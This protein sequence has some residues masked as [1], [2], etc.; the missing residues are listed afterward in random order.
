MKGQ[1]NKFIDFYGT[2]GKIYK[3]PPI[4][5]VVEVPVKKVEPVKKVKEGTQQ[6]GEDEARVDE[7]DS[8][9][10]LIK[11][12][13]VKLE[14]LGESINTIVNNKGYQMNKNQLE[15]LGWGVGYSQES[16]T[17]K[18]WKLQNSKGKTDM[19]ILSIEG[20]EFGAGATSIR[21]KRKH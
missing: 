2:S 14:N 19:I 18:R 9:G 13:I 3:D 6:F 8:T 10:I 17:M 20:H 7:K 11:R 15:K 1:E 4:Y 21:I 16:S 12:H 5:I